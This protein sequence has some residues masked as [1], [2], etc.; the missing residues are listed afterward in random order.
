MNTNILRLVYYA[1]GWSDAIIGVIVTVLAT[2]AGAVF[3][4]NPPLVIAGVA[5]LLSSIPIIRAPDSRR[6][7]DQVWVAYVRLILIAALAYAV[8]TQAQAAGADNGDA[9]AATASTVL[10]MLSAATVLLLFFLSTA[11]RYGMRPEAS[12]RPFA[13]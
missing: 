13:A 10:A 7:V 2:A 11:R 4:W 1:V 12:S 9:V 5:L 3:Y 8:W 6:V